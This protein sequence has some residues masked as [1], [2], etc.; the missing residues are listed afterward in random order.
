MTL[1]SLLDGPSHVT[2]TFGERHE[3]IRLASGRIE[4]EFRKVNISYALVTTQRRFLFPWKEDRVMECWDITA[5]LRLK[6]GRV[7]CKKQLVS[8]N[9]NR[10]LELMMLEVVKLATLD[11]T[12]RYQD[13]LAS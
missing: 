10:A 8:L 5:T 1:Q 6:D 11:K 12:K 7:F 3:I 4:P 9:F 2:T 13:R